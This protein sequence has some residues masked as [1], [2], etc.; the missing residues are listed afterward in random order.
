M[1]A[2]TDVLEQ[3]LLGDLPVAEVPAIQ[4]HLSSCDVCQQTLTGLEAQNDTVVLQLRR[5]KPVDPF[6]A[7][8]SCQEML[9][10][11]VNRED[12]ATHAQELSSVGDTAPPGMIR[13]YRMLEPLGSGGMGTVYR[14]LHTKL[15]RIVAVKLLPPE[16]MSA[17]ALARFEREMR[18]VG[19]LDHPHVVRATDAGVAEGKP[20][21]VMELLDGIDL[22][23]LVRQQGPLDV[24]VACAIVRQAALGVQYAFEQ[25]VVHR[26]IK[27]SNL[28][29]ARIP[30]GGWQVKVL[31][32]GLALFDQPQI[33]PGELTS[34]GQLM[35]TLD[36]MAPEQGE[37]T[38]RVDI[39]ADVYSLGAT[40]F[41]LLTGVAPLAD[42]RRD[43]VM[44]K[45]TALATIEP[46]DI[47]TL[48][49]D[50]P[51]PLAALIR[52]LL[53]KRPEDRPSRPIEVVE[54]LAPFAAGC[55]LSKLPA[56]PVTKRP[57]LPRVDVLEL[58]SSNL[59]R[60][61]RWLITLAGLA[62]VLLLAVLVFKFTTRD[63]IVTVQLDTPQAISSIHVD[64]HVVGWTLGENPQ[65]FR[66]EVKPGAVTS[67][68]LRAEDGTEIH[69]EIPEH[70]LTIA[71]GKSYTLT[72]STQRSAVQPGP[73]EGNDR[74]VIDW[75]RSLGGTIGGGNPTIGYVVVKSDEALPPGRFDLV[76][77][78]LFQRSVRDEDFARLRN[79]P[80]FTTL[81]AGETALGDEAI[82][83]LKGLPQL[84]G[85][86]LSG[87]KLTDV[88]LKSLTRF[89]KLKHL[90]VAG[91]QVT[92]EGVASITAW[93]NLSFLFLD[94]C[95]IT[96]QSVGVLAR[97]TSLRHL[98]VAGTKLS[99]AGGEQLRAALPQCKIES[100]YGV[101]EPESSSMQ[102]DRRDRSVAEWAHALGAQLMLCKLPTKSYQLIQSGDPLP[103]GSFELIDLNLTGR[104]I[105]DRD[106][107]RIDGLKACSSLSVSGTAIT[108]AGLASL[109][110]LP[111]LKTISIAE[112]QITD[113]G[114]K[115]LAAKYPTLTVFHAGQSK[116]T[117]DGIRPLVGGR[118]LVELRLD[119]L[120]L[121]DQA[122]DALSEFKALRILSLKATKVTRPGVE[123]LHAALPACRI[124]S[125]YG[126][127]EYS[128][129][130]DY[131]LEFHFP[132]LV[133]VP[134]LKYD[135]GPVTV[136]VTMHQTGSAHFSLA[137][138]GKS[139]VLFWK[140]EDWQGV[141]LDH[142]GQT[143]AAIVNQAVP[144]DR[145]VK[146]ACTFD[147]ETLLYFLD[148]KVVARGTKS[149]QEP[150]RPA[151][152]YFGGYVEPSYR[153]QM[154][155]LRVSKV[156][157]YAEDYVPSQRFESDAD[158]VALYHFDEGHGNTLK[159]SSGND[160][161][162]TIRGAVWVKND[163]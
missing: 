28:M 66:L 45:L 145:T 163:P 156:A 136:E 80:H 58:A 129:P 1:H 95:A 16:K 46:P 74:A 147:G 140:N 7:E 144:L 61:Q 60:R 143:L 68:V 125:D 35:G 120:P 159:D 88:G 49:P 9:S 5:G 39:R 124:D 152:G 84:E 24:S 22:D 133:T 130:G 31:D 38:H 82:A 23:G 151:G 117:D 20:F 53:S 3:Y 2:S 19:Q 44:K 77:V 33:A 141:K 142:D 114:L 105:Q 139:R 4:E 154:D 32:L 54:L 146:M 109:G 63:G 57:V 106:L 64:G 121:T 107:V 42:P 160:H 115:V 65:Q 37:D 59:Q 153:G 123:R 148:G 71:A 90:H 162:G 81:I 72:A 73:M 108:D 131:A 30:S 76:T 155:E 29:L 51:A 17:A 91:T 94:R 89:Q 25:G 36:Y 14:A 134:T 150:P 55:E 158:T 62:G 50:V 113:A 13:D 119:G 102:T 79:L 97:Q 93:A 99:Q 128:E 52:R 96:D 100:D 78:D 135:G 98:H 126:V 161:H 41:R 40:L 137:I 103:D 67:I 92:D 15:D 75:V 138:I 8:R 34:D 149:P 18:I 12:S 127:F 110:D 118:K 47:R 83:R 26:D 132:S 85:V 48:R 21:L 10:R 69:A 87:T 101:F 111:Q 70:K 116:L 104:S 157:R 86:Y 27:P 43:T 112:T 56:D 122:V 6:E 11:L